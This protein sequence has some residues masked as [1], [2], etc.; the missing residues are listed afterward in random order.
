MKMIIAFVQPF[1]GTKV[2]E[3][4]HEVELLSG[5][6]LTPVR[7]FGR[8]RTHEVSRVSET[9]RHVDI[10]GADACRRAWPRPLHLQVESAVG[11]YLSCS[12][13]NN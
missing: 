9:E 11:T 10:R 7:G 4:L 5:A 2:V 13:G 6:T 1:I 3:A 8:G 12:M